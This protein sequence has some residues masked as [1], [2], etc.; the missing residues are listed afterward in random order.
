[1]AVQPGFCRA[2]LET[3]ETDFLMKRRESSLSCSEVAFVYVTF[4][5]PY[6]I[7]FYIF[8]LNFVVHVR[9][10]EVVLIVSFYSIWASL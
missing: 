3:Q 5:L 6:V 9:I 4:I 10:T 2:L 8:R 1:M 7:M